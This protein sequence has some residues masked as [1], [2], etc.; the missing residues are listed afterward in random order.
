MMPIC[1]QFS[2]CQWH[3][4]GTSYRANFLGNYHQTR[5]N[6][7]S[8]R[9]NAACLFSGSWVK[10]LDHWQNW[11][12]MGCYY[13]V[14]FLLLYIVFNVFLD[15]LTE[16]LFFQCSLKSSHRVVFFFQCS[17][18]SSHRVTFTQSFISLNIFRFQLIWL[19]E[20]YWYKILYLGAF[21]KHLYTSFD[22]YLCQTRYFVIWF[23]ATDI[24]CICCQP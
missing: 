4:L 5:L 20:F 8:W 2:F 10:L 22:V 21:L 12:Y 24:L 17:L 3:I 23:Y 6:C 11:R 7:Y 18:K 16:W 14:K 9:E 1:L 15:L 13:F 19:W